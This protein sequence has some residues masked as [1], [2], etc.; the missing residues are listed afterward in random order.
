MPSVSLSNRY[1]VAV[2]SWPR[3]PLKAKLN[4]LFWSK[5]SA[6]K[7]SVCM[8]LFLVAVLQHRCTMAHIMNPFHVT[9]LPFVG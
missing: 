8:I 6:G 9:E 1:P 4:V 3:K 2:R 7:F 5:L